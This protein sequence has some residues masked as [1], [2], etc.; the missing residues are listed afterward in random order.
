MKRS[1]YFSFVCLSLILSGLQGCV[2]VDEG[3]VGVKKKFGKISDKAL[4][5]GVHLYLPVANEV[6]LWDIKTHKRKMQLDLPSNEGLIVKFE[7]T[8][9]FRPENVIDIR[10]KIGSEYVTR[11]LDPELKSVF[12]DIIGKQG[13]A[14]LITNPENLAATA[15]N[16]LKETLGARG[17][18]VEGLRVTK[19]DL[20]LKFKESIERKIQ[21]EEKVKEMAFELKSAKIAADIEIARAEGAAKAQ[22]IVKKTL[23]PAYLQYLWISTL[24]ENPNVI[25]VST[26]ANMPVFRTVGEPK[27]KAKPAPLK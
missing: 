26:E 19:L 10:K 25:Y 13:V 15:T 8:V 3:Y 14:E 22:E 27:A 24:N 21:A 1:L 16:A 11:V 18:L 5:P 7:T 12:R 4:K 23:S 6:E 17:I 20:P 9:L 2:V